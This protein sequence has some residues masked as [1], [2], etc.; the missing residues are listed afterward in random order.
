MPAEPHVFTYMADLDLDLIERLSPLQPDWREIALA[1]VAELR[2]ARTHIIKEGEVPPWMIEAGAY[3][4]EGDSRV[5]Y[6]EEH[7]PEGAVIR[8]LYMMRDLPPSSL[9]ASNAV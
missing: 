4:V 9:D 1:L 5:Y 7:L 3:D 8:T 6:E 2:E